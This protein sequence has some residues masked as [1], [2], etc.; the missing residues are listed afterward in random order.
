M[1]GNRRFEKI[2]SPFQIK[3]E[4]LRNRIGSRFNCI[5]LYLTEFTPGLSVHTGIGLLAVPFHTD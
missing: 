4:N 5:E 3:E 1:S 2:F